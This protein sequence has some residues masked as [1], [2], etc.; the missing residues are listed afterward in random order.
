MEQSRVT[1]YILNYMK[2]HNILS[3]TI[4]EQTGIPEE[5]LTAAYKEPLFAD[6][7]LR[8]CVFLHLSPE[9]IAHQIHL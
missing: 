1:E 7:F 9:E 5:K 6:E 2:E 8:L 3:S 4:S